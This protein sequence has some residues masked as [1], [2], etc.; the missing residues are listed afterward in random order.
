LSYWI[1]YVDDCPVSSVIEININ[2]RV[3]VVLVVVDVKSVFSY[4]IMVIVYSVC[5][6]GVICIII[7]VNVISDTVRLVIEI[8]MRI[9]A[10]EIVV[11]AEIAV[12]FI[13][14]VFVCDVVGIVAVWGVFVGSRSSVCG[15][16]R[17]W[18]VGR[19]SK[20]ALIISAS[21]IFWRIRGSVVEVSITDVKVIHGVDYGVIKPI[22][23]VFSVETIWIILAF[24]WFQ[25]LGVGGFIAI[26]D[27]YKLPVS[28]DIT[29]T[30]S[31][32]ICRVRI[33]CKIASP[34]VQIIC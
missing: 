3:I 5:I 25:K 21:W 20:G 32:I 22:S 33:I 29:V 9:I 17:I 15:V 13:Y 30:G 16:W 28:W 24:D 10:A 6:T 7:C 14:V 2:K 23:G 1:L 12:D 4:V 19:V 18:R 11:F 31:V 8:A 27:A 26:V 34:I